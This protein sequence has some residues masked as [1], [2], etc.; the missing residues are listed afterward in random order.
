[1]KIE[2]TEEQLLKELL[3]TATCTLTWTQFYVTSLQ[4]N[5]GAHCTTSDISG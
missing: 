2:F 5:A 3:A 1:V 4:A